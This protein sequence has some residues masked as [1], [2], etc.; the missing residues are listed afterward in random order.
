MTKENTILSWSGGKDAALALHLLKEDNVKIESL[1]TTI[2]KDLQRITM[3]GVHVDLLMQQADSLGQSID[4]IELPENITMSKYNA[5]M[6]RFL[7][8]K[9]QEHVSEIVFGDIFLQDLRNYRDKEMSQY[10]LSTLYPLWQKSTK[11]IA[12]QFI[13]LGFK[14]IIVAISSDKLDKSYA[15]REFDL[16]FIN[17][18]PDTVDPCGENG[19]FH[20]FVYDGPIFSYPIQLRTGEITYKKYETSTDDDCFCTDETSSDWDKGFWFCDL[21]LEN[22]IN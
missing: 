21:I 15:G 22:P 14:A 10:N 5:I 18:L 6:G 2:N 17:S 4:L 9:V 19:E 12:E 16:D 1:F 13:S 8:G 20:T 3:H 11:Q 7:K